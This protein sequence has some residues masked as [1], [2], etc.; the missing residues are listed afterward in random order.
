[1]FELEF[2]ARAKVYNVWS[3]NNFYTFE[4]R[5]LLHESAI[6]R[7]CLNW[8]IEI[9][10]IAHHI[11]WH[12]KYLKVSSV[13]NNSWIV[14]PWIGTCAKR[15]LWKYFVSFSWEIGLFFLFFYFHENFNHVSFDYRIITKAPFIVIIS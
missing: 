3:W 7:N 5:F 13:T 2:F 14:L 6:T 15:L 4:L 8:V 10:N 11:P 12:S 1:M 9:T